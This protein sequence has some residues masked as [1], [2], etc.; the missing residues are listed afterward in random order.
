[1]TLLTLLRSG[2]G[3][4][5]TIWE[6]IA[7]D[8]ERVHIINYKPDRRNYIDRD[9]TF[10]FDIFC[11]KSYVFSLLKSYIASS[12][13]PPTALVANEEFDLEYF[14]WANYSAPLTYIAHV[15]GDHSYKA[16]IRFRNSI[17]SLY[18]VAEPALSFL[19][20]RGFSSVYHLNYSI[21]LPIL[22]QP[23]KE[24]IAIYV[25]RLACDKGLDR[26]LSLFKEFRKAGFSCFFIGDGPHTPSASL[27]DGIEVIKGISRHDLFELMSK[28]KYLILNS[29]L[30]GLPIV[31]FECVQYGLIPIVSYIDSSINDVLCN[32]YILCS[33]SP[34]KTLNDVLSR[35]VNPFPVGHY[36]INNPALNH[37]LV[38]Q[39]LTHKCRPRKMLTRDLKL[40][41]KVGNPF[42]ARLI[43]LW[44][45]HRW[46]MPAKT[47]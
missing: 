11:P 9:G 39:I 13:S 4:I 14:S 35:P 16:A 40:L 28:A 37:Q 3:G 18:A 38:S 1:M 10:C 45:R 33:L 17:D 15:N 31:F 25:G 22:I 7:V 42:L 32:N 43:S 8:D 6:S 20:C 30:E 47:V 36:R 26:T 24:D 23:P 2:I 44:R 29:Y 5:R 34:H 21:S 46:N 41:D 19:R 12:Y 27:L